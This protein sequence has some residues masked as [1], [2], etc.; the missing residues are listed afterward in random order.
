MSESTSSEAVPRSLTR[1]ERQR[2]A[3]FDEIIEIGRAMLREGREVTLR[4]MAAEMGLSPPAL[5]RYVDSLA[6]L[7]ELVSDA[8][9]TDVVERMVEAGEPYGD[10]PA[11]QIIA[12]A[13]AFRGWALESRAEF[14]LVFAT[15]PLSGERTSRAASGE[16]SHPLV[17]AVAGGGSGATGVEMFADH[18]GGILA[19]L[20]AQR[21]FPVPAVTDLDPAFVALHSKTVSARPELGELLGKDALGL[22][23][24]FEFAW[25]QLLAIVALEVFG[26]IRPR[27]I[28]SGVIF[29][30]QLKEIGN[31]VGMAGDWDRLV[32]V[33]QDVLRRRIEQ[34]AHSG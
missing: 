19:R 26:H 33:S 25:A 12:A 16:P 23:W 7:N 24:L 17:R 18:F 30:A 5:Y 28:E 4:A 29:Q 11:A 13:T 21:A 15:T 34:G 2:L 3:T 22:V 9:F 6:A 27:L 32:R 14:Q 8:I 31:R 10:D 1:R 20:R